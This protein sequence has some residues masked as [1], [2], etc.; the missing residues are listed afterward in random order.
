V[1]CGS[2]VGIATGY[3][4]GG[5]GIESRYRVRFSANVQTGLEPPVKLVLFF[6]S[7]LKMAGA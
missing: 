3:G 4:M 1:G 6:I 7:L 2:S 5:T